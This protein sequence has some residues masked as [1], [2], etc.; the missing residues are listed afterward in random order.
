MFRFFDLFWFDN[1]GLLQG[2]SVEGQ[3]NIQEILS[4]QLL[5][6]QFLT[7]LSTLRTGVNTSSYLCLSLCIRVQATLQWYYLPLQVVTLSARPLTSSLPS[8]WVWSTCSTSAL[9]ESVSSNL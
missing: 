9:T 6:C 3:E 2:F 7:A 1:S 5:L 4:K 8:V